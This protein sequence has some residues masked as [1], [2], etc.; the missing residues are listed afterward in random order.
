MF[1]HKEGIT[2]SRTRN[3]KVRVVAVAHCILNRSTR[4]WT[5]G[6]EVAEGPVREVLEALSSMGL[7]MIQMPCPEFTFCG[8]PRP[9][10][11]RAEYE[12]L[13]GFRE[14]CLKLARRTA[15]EI[16]TITTL[17]REPKIEV[18][19]IIGVERSPTC[20]VNLIP[21][22]VG[23]GFD[24]RVGLG[25]FMEILKHELE[26]TGLNIPMISIDIHSPEEGLS[27][28]KRLVKGRKSNKG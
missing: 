20:S 2:V 13:P 24:Y 15:E 26:A 23:G 27:T 8:N 1:F 22:R 4:W 7:G 3:L 6:K 18:T 9:P 21:F 14:H 5:E 16:K 17:S 11:S 10:R 12:E 19:A 28:L 25:I